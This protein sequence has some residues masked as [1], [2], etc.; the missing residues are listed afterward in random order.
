MSKKLRRILTWVVA[1][2]ALAFVSYVVPIRDRVLDP[3]DGKTRVALVH[4]GDGACEVLGKVRRQ[5]LDAAAC[6]AL[7]VEP[8][9]ETTVKR[10]RPWVLVA[11]FGLYMAGT[12]LWAVR[13][14]ALLA[15]ARVDMPV[16]SVWRVVLEA[17]AGGVLLPGGV[18]GDALRIAAVGARTKETAKV[19]AS[20][21]LDRAVGLLTVCLAALGAA[22]LSGGLGGTD[23]LMTPLFAIPLGSALGWMLLRGTRYAGSERFAATR[24][25]KV[26]TP[27]LAYARAPGGTGVVLRATAVSVLVSL[28][29]LFVIRGLCSALGVTPSSEAWVFAGT[30]FTFMV[31]ALPALPGAWGTG[32]AAFVFFLARAGV[33]PSEALAICLLY[34]IYWYLSA[35]LGALLTIGRR[36]DNERIHS[37]SGSQRS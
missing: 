9:L 17:Q 37:D 6:G 5:T 29:Q 4:H 16:L 36:G 34:R 35:I 25:G 19:A 11:L 15:L 2:V 32:D 10:A 33:A 1:I 18:A 24:V 22:L 12:L 23:G 14:R 26:L 31:S 30:A 28:T 21:F 20:V 13:W 3:D 7:K 27:M 8:G